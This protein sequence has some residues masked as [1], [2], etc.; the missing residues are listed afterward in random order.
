MG[1][2]RDVQTAW[3]NP[4]AKIGATIAGVL[5]ALVVVPGAGSGAVKPSVLA[6]ASEMAP[7]HGPAV[8]TVPAARAQAAP[9][10]EVVLS[11]AQ[12]QRWSTPDQ[13]PLAL[14]ISFGLPVA[15]EDEASPPPPRWHHKRAVWHARHAART[16]PQAPAPE[17]LADMARSN[18][19]LPVAEG[20]DS[21][22]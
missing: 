10:V 15:P 11:H 13:S 21:D 16:V 19:D 20:D 8:R 17:Q 7:R 5:L 2:N 12:L 3:S 22:P 14:P 6:A 9:P 4:R 1:A 18:L